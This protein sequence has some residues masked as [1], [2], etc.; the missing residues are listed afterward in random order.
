[1]QLVKGMR[2][3]ILTVID[4]AA[5]YVEPKRGK[6]HRRWL[7]Q[8]DCGEQSIVHQKKLKS[9]HTRSCGCKKGLHRHGY[10]R[11]PTYNSWDAMLGRC[12]RPS[13]PNF[14]RYGGRGITVCLGWHD[15]SSFL[16]DMGERP[17]GKTLDRID[18]DG[19]Y[20]PGNC[21]WATAREQQQNRRCVSR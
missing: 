1:M 14:K 18:V 3:G 8:C 13:Q 6:S 2:F 16:A 11:T 19:N 17:K 15:F 20:E 5:P 9:G 12:L 7:C 21:R 10:H 4:E